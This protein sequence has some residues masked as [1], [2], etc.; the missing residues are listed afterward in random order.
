M[1]R[2]K[3]AL[4]ALGFALAL[5]VAAL[6]QA[7]P[8]KTITMVLPFPAGSATDGVARFIAEEL[9]KSL[10]QPVIVENK[11]GADGI[12]A[13]QHVMRSEPD[14]YTLFVTTNSTHAVNPTLY[15]QLPYDAVD[16]FT[17]VGGLIRI[18][19]MLC[20]RSDF[21]AQDL[22][23]FIKVAQA[24]T[25]PLSFGSGNTSSRVAGELLKHDAKLK[26]DHVPYRGT[27]Q[28][29]TDLVGGHIKLFFADP[30]AAIS[31][32]NDGKL[33]ALAVTDRTRLPLLPNV[34][35]MIELGYKD[36]EVVSWVAAFMP[37]KA[38]PAIVRRLN[39]EINT[40][41]AR[42]E[43]KAFI[44]KMGATL[45]PTSPAE[46]GAYVKS[47]IKLWARLIEVS[48]LEKK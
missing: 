41:L 20:V 21:P 7:Y 40:I 31:L 5:P 22:A 8:S 4:L 2:L 30:F 1:K 12:V 25:T 42:P 9:R 10:G 39:T 33:K 13:A 36:F 17:P 18:M 15:R 38:D 11:P 3:T 29:V 44:E 6:A 32:I 14:G 37:A 45:M 28:A 27:P 48:G 16:D 43:S 35:T 47:E 19:Q 46:L 26:L 34:P 24:S 23:G